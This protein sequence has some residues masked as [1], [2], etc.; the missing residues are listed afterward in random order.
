MLDP[1]GEPFGTGYAFLRSIAEISLLRTLD[2]NSFAG[3]ERLP[4][5]PLHTRKMPLSVPELVRFGEATTPVEPLK[6]S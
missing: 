2:K 5:S 4:T 6:V 1:A 3:F